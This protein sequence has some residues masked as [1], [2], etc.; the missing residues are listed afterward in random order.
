MLGMRGENFL[1]LETAKQY[2]GLLTFDLDFHRQTGISWKES[3][4]KF[5]GYV[6]V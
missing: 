4:L 3:V 1:V 2:A 6:L 5:L